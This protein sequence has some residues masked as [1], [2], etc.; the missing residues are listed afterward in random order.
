MII[1]KIKNGIFYCIWYSSVINIIKASTCIWDGNVSLWL[2][3]VE[4]MG[5]YLSIISLENMNTSMVREGCSIHNT[6]YTAL[7]I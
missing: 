4:N 7:P 2:N 5:A 6:N 1:F 3:F